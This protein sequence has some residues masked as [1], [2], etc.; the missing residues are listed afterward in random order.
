MDWA[1][2]LNSTVLDDKISDIK[3]GYRINIY[4]KRQLPSTPQ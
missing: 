1:T 3:T 2:V 4:V